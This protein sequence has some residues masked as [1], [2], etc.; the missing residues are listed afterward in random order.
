VTPDAFRINLSDDY[1][2]SGNLLSGCVTIQWT[3]RQAVEV[4]VADSSPPLPHGR[5]DVFWA[6]RRNVLSLYGHFLR[7]QHEPVMWPN[8]KW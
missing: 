2:A 1:T 6:D 5:S 3:E 8:G 4:N 7:P